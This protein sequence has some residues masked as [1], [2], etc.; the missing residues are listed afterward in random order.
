MEFI[1]KIIVIF[2][3]RGGVFK[4]S[5]NEWKVQEYVIENYD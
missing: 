5:G 1:G 2:Q 4:I 3:F